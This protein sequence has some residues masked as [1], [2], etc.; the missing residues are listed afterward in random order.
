MDLDYIFFVW[1]LG[2]PCGNRVAHRQCKPGCRCPSDDDIGRCVKNIR[3]CSQSAPDLDID[4]RSS[5]NLTALEY[6]SE[7]GYFDVVKTLVECGA[8]G[9]WWAIQVAQYYKHDE[10]EKYLK[11][12]GPSS[13]IG[14]C[15]NDI[16]ENSQ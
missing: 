5:E 11:S 4:Y 8:T 7:Y 15:K 13:E 10:I 6:A 1:D 14:T 16:F 2:P 3:E 9:Y 12:K